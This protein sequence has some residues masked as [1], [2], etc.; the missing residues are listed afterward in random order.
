MGKMKLL[1]LA[2]LA[3][4]G[5]ALAK[6]PTGVVPLGSPATWVS[7][8]DYPPVALRFNMTGTTAFKLVVDPTGKP[9]RCDIRISSGFDVLDAATCATVMA[10]ARFSAAHNAK[11]QP[12][13]GAFL[14]SV[15]WMVPSDPPPPTS[16]NFGTASLTIDQTGKI[17]SCHYVFHFPVEVAATEPSYCDYG[18]A[19]L[20]P[21][22]GLELRDGF[23]GPSATVAIEIADV[24][25]PALRERVLAVMP[26]YEKRAL[27][28]H[29]FTVTSDSKL[30]TCRFA[31]QRGTTI[32]A[33]DFCSQ[34]RQQSF[35]PP[36]VAIDKD[37][38]ANGSH[39]LRILLKTVK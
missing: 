4:A 39:I 18:L 19:A 38:V 5:S 31:E 28:I 10:R 36:F 9:T 37:G 21:A 26:G 23:Q 29:N 24:F 11:G 30:G 35:D 17:T 6:A 13:E 20:P 15:R 1:A 27:Y 16:E 12:I 2:M 8:D 3:W 14:S 7:T 32:M 25:T 34:A 33:Q 22:L